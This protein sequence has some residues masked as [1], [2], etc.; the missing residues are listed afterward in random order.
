MKVGDI[1]YPFF[2]KEN[3]TIGLVL[4]RTLSVTHQDL[5]QI[6][7]HGKVY[8]VPMHQIREIKGRKVI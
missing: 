4:G 6:L 7:I 1:V 8:L 3:S 2:E 5:A